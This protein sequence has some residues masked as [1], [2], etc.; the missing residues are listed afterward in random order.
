MQV[1]QVCNKMV[2]D[3]FTQMDALRQRVSDMSNFKGDLEGPAPD[4]KGLETRI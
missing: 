3:A 2:E 1:E 4:M